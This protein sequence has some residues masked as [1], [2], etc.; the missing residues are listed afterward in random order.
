MHTDSLKYTR[1]LLIN[2]TCMVVESSNTLKNNKRIIR[3]MVV[4]YI[5]MI[6]MMGVTLYT[7]RITLNVLGINDF[8]IYNA[9]GGVVLIFS[10]LNA[11]MSSAIQRYLTFE[12]GKKEGRMLTKIF[13]MSIC[14][15]ILISF[16]I[17]VLSETIGLWFFYVKMVIPIDRIEAAFWVYQ[18]S[19][20]S[21][22]VMIMSIPYNA[23]IIAHEKMG[24]FAYVSVLEVV[25][26]LL[27]TYLLLYLRED[28]L[29]LYAIMMLGV[30]LII[31][32]IYSLYC[33][34]HFVETKFI[35]VLDKALFKEMMG[36]AGWNLFGSIAVVS[37]TQGLNILLNI[38]FGPTVNAAR[39]IAIQVQSALINFCVSFQTALNPQITKSYAAGDLKYMH[40]LVFKSVKYSFFLL[41]LL[42]LPIFV[43]TELILTWWLVI[44]PEYTISFVRIILCITMIEVIANPF[45]I[46]AQATG[47]IRNYQILVGGILLLIAP[48][49]YLALRSGALPEE[50]F[51]IQ[52]L[53]TMCAQC[54]RLYLVHIMIKFS[55]RYF[56][57][58]VLCRIIGI[59]VFAGIFSYFI[60]CLLSNSFL[61]I[62][63][64]LL[65][66]TLFTCIAIYYIGF[67]CQEKIFFVGKTKLLYMNLVNSLKK[68][69]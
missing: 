38:F 29:I 50:V 21:C 4:L 7:S 40:S 33:N 19:I 69:N 64:F 9:V 47:H 11:S 49:S 26:K 66:C 42:A 55:L 20:L 30:Q 27:M 51:V 18:L 41:F 39:S 53:V 6:L 10:F 25:L 54:V 58:E 24:V 5:R 67:T 12:L 37:A 61:S 43:K 56:F 17:V 36:F 45:I 62:L 13:N 52:L 15:Q 22:V 1:L 2:L 28:K 60:Q 8:G 68:G 14:I 16:F 23:I 31:R 46:A 63:L 35:L 32:F 44:V 48:F 34:R 65:C 3:N 57:V 59:I